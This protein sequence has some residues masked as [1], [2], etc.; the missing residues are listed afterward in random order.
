MSGADG[1]TIADLIYQLRGD[2]A[3]AAWHGEARDP[4]FL[5]GPIELE[6]SVVV[7]SS[8]SGDVA[9]KLVLVDVSA[10]ASKSIQTSHRIK[11]T[12]QPVGRDG[13][14]SQISS[15]VLD[16]EENAG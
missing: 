15:P 7:D 11:L 3:R 8:R 2:L 13:R 5:L 12:L 1:I 10:G 16:G 9:A 14:P 6:L 4:K